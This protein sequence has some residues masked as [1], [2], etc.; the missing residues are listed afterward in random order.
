MRIN[1]RGLN[2]ATKRLADG[3]RRIYWYPWRGGPLLNGEPGTPEFVASYNAAVASKAPLPEGT[4]ASVLRGY[5]AS[6]DFLDLRE[7]TRRDYLDKIKLI[8]AEYRD[9][10]LAALSD[11][12]TR[13]VF[14]AWRDGLAAKSRRQADYAWQVLAL[15]LAWALD[16][17][18]VTANPCTKG[19]RVY[20]GSRVDKIWSADA[21][22][23][24][25]ASA[26]AHLHLPL[27]LALWTGQRQ[28]DLL[29]LPWSAYDGTRIKLRQSKTGMPVAIRAGAPL[30]AALDAATKH[31]PLILT[32]SR[33]R[34]WTS[35]AFQA[36]W[37][38]AAKTAGII[39]LTFHD[40]RGTAVTRLAIVGCTEAEIAAITGHSLRD[41]RSILDAHYLHRDPVLAENAIRKLERGTKFS[42]QSQTGHR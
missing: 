42:N 35:H 19:G 11:R 39:G 32:N 12:R 37:G 31:G 38:G 36:A 22:A 2:F 25:L 27:L 14:L 26:P 23:A 34:P 41:V 16:R 10:P 5:Q 30:K 33:R 20:S 21:E 24:F 15:M 13:G 8:E 29:R 1:L 28:G 17:G 4:L 18:M 40:L 6:P 3:T 9:F 7:R